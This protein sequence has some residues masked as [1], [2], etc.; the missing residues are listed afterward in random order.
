LE[1]FSWLTTLSIGL[2]L[3]NAYDD[4][5]H[6]PNLSTSGVLLLV[7]MTSWSDSSHARLVCA[8]LEVC[9]SRLLN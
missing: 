1:T 3:A 5:D 4:A 2:V 6:P 9:L 8:V 7:S